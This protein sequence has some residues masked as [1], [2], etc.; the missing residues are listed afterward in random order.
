MTQASFR[1]TLDI[2]PL[3]AALKRRQLLSSGHEGPFFLQIGEGFTIG[4]DEWSGPVIASRDALYLLKETKTRDG[5]HRAGVSSDTNLSMCAKEILT[6]DYADIPGAITSEASW[7]ML[8]KNPC[9]VS[10]LL[11]DEVRTVALVPFTSD[12][13]FASACPLIR[14]RCGKIAPG[15]AEG[16]L[17]N[18]GWQLSRVVLR[19]DAAAV[20]K[21]TGWTP[22][23]VGLCVLGFVALTVAIVQADSLS[24]LGSMGLCLLVLGGGGAL[25]GWYFR[26]GQAKGIRSSTGT[27]IELRRT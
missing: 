16:I 26:R 5:S 10:V 8:V 17:R 6:I 25:L 11:R 1:S 24:A 7:K 13:E 27:G 18:S 9:Q 20:G 12:I 15:D 4:D 19:P 2:A 23:V 22:V 21:R 3:V 14:I